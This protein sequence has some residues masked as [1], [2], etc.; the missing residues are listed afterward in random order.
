MS[1]LFSQALVEEYSE[2]SSLDGEPCAQLNVMPTPHKFWRNDKTMEFSNLSRFGLTLQLLTENRGEELLTL[3]LE[4]FHAKTYQQ[5]AKAQ[6]L[7][8]K[9]QD[10]G[11][12]NGVLFAKWN[13]TTLGWKTAQCSLFEDLELSLEIWPRWGSMRNGVC[14]QREMWELSICG[15]VYGYS[16]PTI[17]K[18]EFKGSSKAR[19]LGSPEFRG[20][21]MSE[22]CRTCETDPIYLN[23]LFAEKVMGFPTMWTG[24]V[25]LEMHSFQEWLQQHSVYCV[26]D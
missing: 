6:E 24:L 22:G 1:W 15:N 10:Y 20:A 25:K 14:Y 7:Q 23:H 11:L 5:P 3:F 19:Y 12:S 4:G 21:K 16:L 13:H 18:N 9:D 2:V 26:K 8:V 17:G